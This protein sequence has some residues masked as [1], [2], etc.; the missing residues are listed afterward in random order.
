MATLDEKD[1]DILKVLLDDLRC[2]SRV[3]GLMAKDSKS[4]PN[5]DTRG[6]YAGVSKSNAIRANAL[7][8]ALKALGD[9]ALPDP[10]VLDG[11]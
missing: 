8:S 6:I 2:E 9:V 10:L 1:A 4:Y 5:P 3:Y 7:L 11:K